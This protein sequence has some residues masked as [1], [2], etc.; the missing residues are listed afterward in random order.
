MPDPLLSS[1]VVTD[2]V[3]TGGNLSIPDHT[4]KL[5]FISHEPN[6]TFQS[7][8]RI[9]IS[10]EIYDGKIEVKHL[11]PDEP[12]TIFTALPIARPR[13][14][15]LVPSPGY[16][17]S[18]AELS[19]EQ[20]WAYLN[21][22]TNISQPINIG[23]VFIYYYGLERNLLIGDFDS[24]FDEIMILRQA[25][26]GNQSFDIYSRS[27]LLNSALSR[28]RMDRLEQLYRLVQPSR[29]SNT[30]LLLAH[31][32]GYDLGV[33][34]LMRLAPNLR[35]VQKH[36]IKKNPYEYKVALSAVLEEE[37]DSPYLPFGSAYKIAEVPKRQH[38]LYANISFPSEIRTPALPSF[39]DY[40]PFA[41]EACRILN[42]AHQRVKQELSSARK[43][44]QSHPA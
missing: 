11:S 8:L 12:S 39:V 18:Y 42:L 13:Q 38:V 28:K 2:L 25:H 32:L 7:G 1:G 6:P 21:W 34:G 40:A 27:A 37:F 20:R 15:E 5:L 44:S 26:A 31:Q 36:Y 19:P 22:L 30:E 35:T 23:F 17:P 24:A 41:N 43:K 16:F 4:A 10:L 33:E 9:S 29:F 3:V 14:P